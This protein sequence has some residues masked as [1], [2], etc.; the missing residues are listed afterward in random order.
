[1]S[2]GFTIANGV[3]IENAAGSSK[4]DRI[5]G[6]SQ[7]NR[8]DGRGGADRMDG[9]GGDDTYVVDN[10]SDTVADSGGGRDTVL[11]RT[12]YALGATSSV[13]VLQAFDLD[14]TA[15]LK[16]T[17]NAAANTITGNAGKNVLDGGAGRDVLTGGLGRDQFLFDTKLQRTNVDHILDFS[18]ADDTI[19]LDRSIFGAFKKAGVLKDAAFHVAE[20]GHLAQDASDRIIYDASSGSLYYD[21]D[22]TGH[23]GA[24]LFAILESG[25]AL[26][27]RD[28]LHR[29]TD[30]LLCCVRQSTH[31]WP[32]ER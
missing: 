30:M 19:R 5:T 21:P 20:S 17:G 13:E 7:A 18:V 15:T 8:I 26:T 32:A 4:A 25:L 1:M 27:A 16:L 2:G 14:G 28:F 6:N 24:S 11:A 29:L 9:L 22:G 23:K 10:R 31:R 12:S 3:V